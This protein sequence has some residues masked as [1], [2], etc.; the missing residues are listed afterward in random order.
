ML[1]VYSAILIFLISSGKGNWLELLEGGVKNT[2]VGW[3]RDASFG[4]NYWEVRE[5]GI[6]PDIFGAISWMLV[7]CCSAWVFTD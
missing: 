4:S 5:I 1:L 6:L 3:G 2:V 7:V